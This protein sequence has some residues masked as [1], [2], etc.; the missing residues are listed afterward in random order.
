MAAS[1]YNQYMYYNDVIVTLFGEEGGLP[2]YV[3]SAINKKTI[4]PKNNEEGAH[5]VSVSITPPAVCTTSRTDGVRNNICATGTVVVVDYKN[6]IFDRLIEHTQLVKKATDDKKNNVYITPKIKIEIK[7]YTGTELFSGFVNDY[8]FSFSGGAPQITIE[9]TSIPDIKGA[10]K[11]EGEQPSP[12]SDWNSIKAFYEGVIEKN[13]SDLINKVPLVYKDKRNKDAITLMDSELRFSGD[14]FEG[15]KNQPY[16]QFDLRAVDSGQN[17]NKL[18]N[19]YYWLANNIVTNGEVTLEDGNPPKPEDYT[20]G[21]KLISKRK[22]LK[23]SYNHDKFTIELPGE[24]EKNSNSEI[25][26]SIIFV[27]NGKFAPYTQVD[28]NEII[29]SSKNSKSLNFGQRIVIPMTSISFETNFANLH[30]QYDILKGANYSS[31][32]V[33]GDTSPAPSNSGQAQ[34][35]AASQSVDNQNSATAISFTCYNVMSFVLNNPAAQI[36]FL[37]Y[38]EYGNIHPMSGYGTVTAVTYDI[39]GGVVSSTVKATKVFSYEPNTTSNES[40]S[41][42]SEDQ[43]QKTS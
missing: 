1:F 23:G 18:V 35:A 33:K 43:A 3:I 2:E 41:S 17:S 27:Q 10:P 11:Q 32:T 7:C 21:K 39:S 38:D 13:Y 29:K 8:K 5:L 22:P 40:D 42:S 36:A 12:L 4:P 28:F 19:I 26:S 16:A 37:V 14:R 34:Q 31:T 30:L 24:E 15:D 6:N 20:N 25:A 9:W